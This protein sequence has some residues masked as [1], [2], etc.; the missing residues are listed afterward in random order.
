MRSER[1]AERRGDG[2][3]VGLLEIDRPLRYR[4]MLN[5]EVNLRRATSTSLTGVHR[6]VT[7]RLG[8][9]SL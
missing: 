9:R 1:G 6:I 8:P 4:E 7:V 3:H 2:R 5:I